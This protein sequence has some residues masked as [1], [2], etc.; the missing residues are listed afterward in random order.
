MVGREGWNEGRKREEK[1]KEELG[2]VYMIPPR[3][4]GTFSSRLDGTLA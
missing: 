3:R 2:P 1:K 4:D